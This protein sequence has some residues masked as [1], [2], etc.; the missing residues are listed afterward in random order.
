MHSA[1]IISLQ[2]LTLGPNGL[3]LRQAHPDF[4]LARSPTSWQTK[5][6]PP[7]QLS[8]EQCL[9]N[10]NSCSFI[11]FLFLPPSHQNNKSSKQ[12]RLVNLLRTESACGG[13]AT[14]GCSHC[15]RVSIFTTADTDLRFT[16][17]GGWHWILVFL[18]TVQWLFPCINLPLGSPQ[19]DA[20][21]VHH[22]KVPFYAYSLLESSLPPPCSC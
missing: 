21:P 6:G 7:H 9:D 4:L 3:S 2:T 12:A 20:Q 15:V 5:P 1:R 11:Y 8:A 17:P 14:M 16:C 22:G 18:P 10:K 19:G 13:L